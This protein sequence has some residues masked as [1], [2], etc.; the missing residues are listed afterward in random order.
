MLL[1][2][3]PARLDRRRQLQR[4]AALLVAGGGYAEGPTQP[5]APAEADSLLYYFFLMFP[6]SLIRYIARC[7]NHY[8]SQLVVVSFDMRRG[9]KRGVRRKTV[10]D[11]STPGAR[12]RAPKYFVPMDVG[13]FLVWLAIH[14]YMGVVDIGGNPRCYWCCDEALNIGD[15]WVK[16]KMARETFLAYNYY[17]HVAEP[18]EQAT[19]DNPSKTSKVDKFIAMVKGIIR[20]AWCLGEFFSIDEATEKMTG[21]CKIKQYNPKK[22]AK[23]HIKFWVLAAVNGYC[24]NFDIYQGAGTASGGALLDKD[25]K[26]GPRV[27]LA[28]IPAALYH[29]NFTDCMDNYFSS[30]ALFNTLLQLGIYAVATSSTRSRRRCATRRAGRSRTP[31]RTP[32]A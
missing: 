12:P 29:K 16:S 6:L 31:T 20:S 19:T 1:Q 32:R 2:H 5:L 14:I 9:L 23:H 3:A 28:L 30:I 10:C 21:A 18:N 11:E 24:F 17:L 13:G 8:A 4:P 22:P 25:D 15:E 26:M 27:I 7:T